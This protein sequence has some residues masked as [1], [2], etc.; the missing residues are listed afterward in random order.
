MRLRRYLTAA[1]LTLGM[2]TI[3]SAVHAQNSSALN[4]C[5]RSANWVGVVVGYHSTGVNDPPDHSVLTGPFVTDGWTKVDPGQCQTIRNPFNARYMFWWGYGIGY[6]DSS[7]TVETTE[8]R[9]GAAFCVASGNKGF[10]FEDE[11]VSLNACHAAKGLWVATHEVDTAVN[12]TVDFGGSD[13]R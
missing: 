9:P 10:T 2:S 5:N 1:C 12:A 4:F 13:T 3:S 8:P 7:P 6:N 11:N